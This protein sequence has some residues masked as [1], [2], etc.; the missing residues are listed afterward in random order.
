MFSLIFIHT[1]MIS[2]ALLLFT[3]NLVHLQ[4]INH[5]SFHFVHLQDINLRSFHL[6]HLQ[7]ISHISFH[8]SVEHS[9]YM[10]HLL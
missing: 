10:Y 8:L 5:R 7:D 9:E 4:D 1:T 3:S 6:V 2:V